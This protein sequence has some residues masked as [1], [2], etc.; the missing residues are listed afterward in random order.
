[1]TCTLLLFDID[2]TLMGSHGA[3]VQAMQTVAAELFGLGHKW[4]G[5]EFAGHLDPLIFG[6]FARNNGLAG[7]AD[8]HA[9]FRHRYL[10]ELPLALERK[11]PGVHLM[12]GIA[13]TLALLRHRE[14][15]IGDVMLGLLTGNY[16]DAVPIKFSAVG[17]DPSWFRIHAL[18]D[19]A[20]TRPDLVPHAMRQYESVTGCAIEP[21]RVVVIGDTPRDVH[22]AKTHAC[23]AVGVA[24]GA[25]SVEALQQA[26]ADVAVA[27]L[28]DPQPLLN[29]LS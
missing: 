1:M 26:G 10:R 20:P 18:G 13:D 7:G 27:D 11:G 9:A 25:Y 8:Q 19:H 5:I 17:L 12:P 22:C 15:S 2:G 4:D 3:G 21:R 6:E 29:L 28:S 23:R 16:T 24:T 14:Q